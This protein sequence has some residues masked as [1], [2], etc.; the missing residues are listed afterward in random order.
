MVLPRRQRALEHG[1]RPQ[2]ARS[3]FSLIEVIVAI[4]IVSALTVIIMRFTFADSPDDRARVDAAADALAGLA[5]VIAYRDPTRTPTTFRQVIGAYPGKL[6][7]LTTQI[8]GGTDKGVCGVTA[9][10]AAAPPT[11]PVP[12]GYSQKWTKPFYYRQLGTAGT[13]LAPGFTAQDALVMISAVPSATLGANGAA[14]M[15]IR[16]PSVVLRDAEALDLV[17]DGAI[18]GTTGIIRYASTN[19]TQVDYYIYI[20]GC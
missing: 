20:T 14:I 17:V 18:S 5:N 3:G 15:A 9:Y 12:P 13:I 19:P 2:P 4:A 1:R 10:S 11:T 7:H 8:V 6:S 16:M